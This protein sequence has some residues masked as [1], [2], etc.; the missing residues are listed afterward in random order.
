MQKIDWLFVLATVVE[1][2]WQAI[3]LALALL[4]GCG[5]MLWFIMFLV[6]GI[7]R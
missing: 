6:Q 4:G 7:L 3:G 2:D 1:W 5:L